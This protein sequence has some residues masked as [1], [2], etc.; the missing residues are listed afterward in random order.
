MPDAERKQ[1]ELNDVLK[2]LKEY[3]ANMPKYKKC[4]KDLLINAKSV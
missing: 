2:I 4:K 3:R 1:N